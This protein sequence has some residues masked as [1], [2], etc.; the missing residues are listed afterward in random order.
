VGDGQTR[1]GI[2]AR[3]QRPARSEPL[4]EI[5]GMT[6]IILDHVIGWQA[7][8]TAAGRLGTDS[9]LSPTTGFT[10]G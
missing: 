10:L 1:V 6:A 4:A 7:T 8:T 2:S 9:L 5:P 3:C